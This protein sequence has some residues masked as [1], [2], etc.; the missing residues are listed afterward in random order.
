MPL[1]SSVWFDFPALGRP[2]EAR[3]AVYEG[4]LFFCLKVS[5]CS[6][7]PVRFRQ[8]RGVVYEILQESSGQAFG[9]EIRMEMRVL[10]SS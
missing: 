9:T 6:A 4:D 3:K 10:S 8:Q 5:F 7:A 1:G 2:G